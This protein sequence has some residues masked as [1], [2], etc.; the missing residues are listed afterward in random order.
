MCPSTRNQAI[1]IWLS[2]LSLWNST[3]IRLYD[4]TSIPD[5]PNS[6]VSKGTMALL[7]ELLRL[8]QAHSRR[9]GGFQEGVSLSD[10]A[11]SSGVPVGFPEERKPGGRLF[12]RNL[13]SH[14]PLMVV[15]K[16]SRFFPK[17][18]CRIL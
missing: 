7:Y 3:L 17:N 12:A 1:R 9:A 18:P 16:T 13:L 8:Q 10:L 5:K 6:S 14:K 2:L 15:Y 4:S 11:L